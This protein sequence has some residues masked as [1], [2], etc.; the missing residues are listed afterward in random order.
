MIKDII[1]TKCKKP[2]FKKEEIDYR[3]VFSVSGNILV[4]LINLIYLFDCASVYKA[5]LIGVNPTPAKAIDFVK[6]RL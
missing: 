4:K 6:D 1:I 5:V 2:I 3:E